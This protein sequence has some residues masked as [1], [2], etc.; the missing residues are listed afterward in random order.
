MAY[1]LVYTSVDAD[2]KPRVAGRPLGASTEPTED[3]ASQWLKEAEV[4]LI[5]ALRGAGVS[6]PDVGDDG[7][8]LIKAWVADYP[9]GNLKIAWIDEADEGREMV[10]RFWER[11]N[12]I[13]GKSGFYDA[14]LNGGSTGSSSLMTRGYVRNNDDGKSIAD[15]DFDPMFDRDT[16]F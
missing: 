14:M 7:A 4:A 6:L 11:L 16:E 1:T 5:G 9:V 15:G 8:E 12:E 10:N 3:E 13:P 2:I